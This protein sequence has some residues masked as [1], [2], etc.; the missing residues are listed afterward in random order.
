[1]N[2]RPVCLSLGVNCTGPEKDPD[3]DAETRRR[4]PFLRRASQQTLLIER[5]ACSQAAVQQRQS[6]SYS[7]YRAKHSGVEE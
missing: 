6:Q 2:R 3:P 1:M 7:G 5:E 4:Q